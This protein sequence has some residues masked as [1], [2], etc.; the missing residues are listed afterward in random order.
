MTHH[1]TYHLGEFPQASAARRQ[2]FLHAIQQFQIAHHQRT[3]EV[4]DHVTAVQLLRDLRRVQLRQSAHDFDRRL[5]HSRR[6]IG[7][8]SRDFVPEPGFEA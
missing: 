6:L 3:G 4:I 8:D 1:A 2:Q 7:T 5:E